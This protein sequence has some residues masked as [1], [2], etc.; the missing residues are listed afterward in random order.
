M[1]TNGP[2]VLLF[3]GPSGHGKTELARRLGRLLPLDI[4]T[5]NCTHPSHE[6]DPFGPW[7]PSEGHKEGPVANN[8]LASHNSQRC[9]V[10]HDEF[11]KT[12][13][14][15]GRRLSKMIQRDCIGKF[16]AGPPRLA[17]TSPPPAATRS[18]GPLSPPMATAVWL[19]KVTCPRSGRG[20]SSTPWT[21]RSACRWSGGYLATREVREGRQGGRFVVGVGREGGGVEVSQVQVAGG[22]TEENMKL[23]GRAGDRRRK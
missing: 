17:Q 8:F 23:E 7:R 6:T 10:S 4:L 21:W 14:E 2:L 20:A 12:K 3:A 13:D 18:A 16:G 1:P 19:A 5:V 11:E 22:S 9:I 15:L